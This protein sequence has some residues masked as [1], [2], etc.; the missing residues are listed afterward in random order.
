[1]FIDTHSHIHFE[2]YREE[3]DDL[4]KRAA[5]AGVE[6]IIT[7]GVDE[8]DSGQAVAVARAYDNVYATVGLHPNDADRGYEALE[9]IQRLVESE[10][11]VGIGE[12]GLD[13]YREGAD[14]DSQERALRF[15]IDLAIE[16]DLPLVF[17]IRDAF[18]DFFMILDNYPEVRGLVHCFTAGVKEAQ[19]ALDRGLMIALNGI[20][21]FTKDDA[22]LEAAKMIPLESLVLETDCPF[23]TPTPKRGQRNEPANVALTAEFLA[24][25][26]N[27]SLEDFGVATTANAKRL[28]GIE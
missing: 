11:I 5:S 21:T 27:E 20:M 7:V 14:R 25:L 22:Q 17:H 2:D 16:H 15:Q 10:S 23:L 3:L 1:M 4:L 24:N 12:C 19:G 6:H 13:Y 8:V 18:E 26:R 9:E 28:F